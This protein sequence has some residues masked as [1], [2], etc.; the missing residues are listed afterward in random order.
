[1]ALLALGRH[2][3]ARGAF[4]RA[5]PLAP[6]RKRALASRGHALPS[7]A[8]AEEAHRAPDRAASMRHVHA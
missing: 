1:M 2:A 4:E 3:E 6:N 5:V 7:P 8:R